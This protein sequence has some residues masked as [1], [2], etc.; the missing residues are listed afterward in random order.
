MFD[1]CDYRTWKRLEDHPIFCVHKKTL[2]ADWSKDP[3]QYSEL[4]TYSK[5]M[6]E[7][8]VHVDPAP[9]VSVQSAVLE[10]DL[11]NLAG[12]CEQIIDRFGPAQHELVVMDDF[13]L[14]VWLRNERLDLCVYP[15]LPED[16][17]ILVMF[18]HSPFIGD[19][20]RF[21]RVDEL[22]GYLERAVG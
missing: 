3:S 7:F 12:V 13:T 10:R 21:N 14:F 4:P 8:Y 2:I 9:D 20:L 6:P 19:E 5:F 15:M 16:Q 17:A 11:K 22:V 18:V 1:P